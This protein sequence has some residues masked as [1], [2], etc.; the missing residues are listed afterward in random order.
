MRIISTLT[1]LVALAA[2][3]QAANVLTM[4]FT[5]PLEAGLPGA[6]LNFT[7]TITNNDLVHDEYINSDS[8]TLSSGP[9]LNDSPFLANAPIFVARG[10]TSSPAFLAFTVTIPLGQPSGDYAGVF[11]I[12]GGPDG[13]AGTATDNLDEAPFTVQVV[14]EPATALVFGVALAGLG[15]F[16]RKQRA[17]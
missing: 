15:L 3:A 12:V 4:N 13:G 10:A 9:V 1:L 8:F 5:S 14:P 16:G 2:S 7:A 17:C 11:T 6:V